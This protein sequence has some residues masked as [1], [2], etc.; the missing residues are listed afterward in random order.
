MIP[1]AK[2]TDAEPLAEHP[3]SHDDA[4][5][6]APAPDDVAGRLA[7]LNRGIECA[8]RRRESDGPLLSVNVDDRH[9]PGRGVRGP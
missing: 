9:V 6:S 1:G 4:A 7:R 2:R 8:A 5:A 3:P